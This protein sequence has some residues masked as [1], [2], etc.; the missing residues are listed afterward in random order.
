[1]AGNVFKINAKYHAC[2]TKFRVLTPNRIISLVQW[3]IINTVA[4]SLGSRGS[5]SLSQL[6]LGETQGH[7]LDSSQIHRRA[8]TSHTHTHIRTNSLNS[9]VSPACQSLDWGRRHKRTQREP[10]TPHRQPPGQFRPHSLLAVSQQCYATLSPT[11]VGHFTYHT[12]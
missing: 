10:H 7:T 6:T 2:V 8:H 5:W 1:M 11:T 4:S 12:T 3:S 9:P